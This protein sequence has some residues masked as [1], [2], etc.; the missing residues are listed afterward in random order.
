MAIRKFTKA[1]YK[2]L[3]DFCVATEE[4]RSLQ[5]AA[6]TLYH[7]RADLQDHIIE[8]AY[9]DAKTALDHMNKAFSAMRAVFNDAEQEEAA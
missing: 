7:Y 6:Q 9:R 2:A 3:L 5:F 8:Y 4:C 1:E